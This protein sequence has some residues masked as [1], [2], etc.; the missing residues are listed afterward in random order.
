MPCLLIDEPC[1]ARL[2]VLTTFG[3]WLAQVRERRGLSQRNLA[4]KAGVS[5]ATV[6]KIED[7]LANA[8]VE[9]VK[10]LAIALE[11]E[12]AEAFRVWSEDAAQQQGIE[13]ERIPEIPIPEGYHDLDDPIVRAV[14]TKAAQDT[15]K[16]VADAMRFARRNS[17][18]TI[19]GPAPEDEDPENNSVLEGDPPRGDH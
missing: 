15:Y 2:I 18:G 9:M 16:S 8:S 13:I 17:P 11:V 12:P 1:L 7:G 6:S 5:S 14:A 3:V 10:K 19:V 4:A